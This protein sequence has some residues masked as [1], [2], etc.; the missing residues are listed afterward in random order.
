MTFRGCNKD[1]YKPVTEA[2]TKKKQL[3][4]AQREELLRTLRTRF[5]KN[6]NRHKGLDWSKVEAKLGTNDDT[7]WSLHEMERTGGR[8]RIGQLGPVASGGSFYF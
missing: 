3:S 6:M 7:L 1:W 8:G 4:A 2:N 5:E